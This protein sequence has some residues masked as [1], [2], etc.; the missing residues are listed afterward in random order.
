MSLTSEERADLLRAR[1]MLENPGFAMRL[2]NL[3]GLPVE[4]AF[5]FLPRG[6]ARAVHATAR[7]ALRATLA[8]AVGTMSKR[9]KASSNAFH[10]TLATASGATGGFFGIVALPIE[11]PV[12]TWLMLRSI[13]DIARSEGE[14]LR[15]PE[16][17]N[18][19]IEVFALGGRARGDDAAETGY[20]AMRTVLARAVG[21]AAEFIARKGLVE[22]GAPI[23][24]RVATSLASRF[25]VTL[26]EKAAAQAVPFVG[27]AGG[28]AVNA[29]FLAHFQ[30]MARGHFTIR[31]LER[32]H[33][34]D[35]VRAI[36]EEPPLRAVVVPPLLLPGA[37]S[38]P[39][40]VR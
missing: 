12:S 10:K 29:L 30:K 37:A 14:D 8:V 32:T 26:S 33:G 23:L 1:E 13:A 24:V 9:R 36:Y 2:T 27:A 34:T 38:Q 16:V 17:R 21:E 15:S 4:K 20:F 31:R 40:R 18:A 25:S 28:A 22:E 39:P 5:E 19:C 35:A 11:L 7:G 6:L 3:I